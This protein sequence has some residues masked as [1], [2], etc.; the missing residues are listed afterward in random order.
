M[1]SRL[2]LHYTPLRRAAPAYKKKFILFI[3]VFAEKLQL[4]T[5]LPL[6]GAVRAFCRD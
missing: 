2:K 4:F 6:I 1:R 5:A 3:A